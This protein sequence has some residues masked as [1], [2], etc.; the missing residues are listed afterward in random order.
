VR[1]TS[2]DGPIGGPV[3]SFRGNYVALV[4]AKGALFFHA[5]RLRMG[6][7]TFNQFLQNYYGGY[8]Y[9]EASGPGMLEVAEAT[10]NCDLQPLYDEWVHQP[11]VS[12]VP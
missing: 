2:R 3:D 6:D 1:G 9:G 10:C 5:L 8:R 12:T 4:Y 11:T 7:E